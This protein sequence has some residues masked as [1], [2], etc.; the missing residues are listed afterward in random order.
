[1]ANEILS[2][3]SNAWMAVSTYKDLSIIMGKNHDISNE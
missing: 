1:M 2:Y 3:E